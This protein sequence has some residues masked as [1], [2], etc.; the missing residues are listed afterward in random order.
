MNESSDVLIEVYNIK[1]EKLSILANSYYVPGNYNLI[2]D[3][4]NFSNGVY[5]V[6]YSF[7]GIIQTQKITLI[8]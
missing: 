5:F 8:K 1:G 4:S 6:R 7:N 2:W 3:G